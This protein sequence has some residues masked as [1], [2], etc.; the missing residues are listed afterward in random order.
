[1]NVTPISLNGEIIKIGN[2]IK[3][4][5]GKENLFI[6]VLQEYEYNGKKHKYIAT[7][8]L[9]GR[10]L[11]KYL[12]DLIV[13][14]QIFIKGIVV[15]SYVSEKTDLLTYIKCIELEKLNKDKGVEIL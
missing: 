6:D 12:D 11:D 10:I 5:H 7:I 2:I 1:M 15:N 3:D 9:K 13:G 8:K 14:E 4:K